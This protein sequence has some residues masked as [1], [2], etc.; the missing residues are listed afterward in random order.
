M[1]VTHYIPSLVLA[2]LLVFSG[3]IFTPMAAAQSAEND[4]ELPNF[5]ITS[6]KQ[7]YAL[8]GESFSYYLVATNDT[9]YGLPQLSSSIPAGLYFNGEQITGTPTVAGDYA[10]NFTVSNECGDTTETVNLT[11]VAADSG[12]A[13]SSANQTANVG[14]NEIPDTG[15]DADSALTISFYVLALLL[16][17]GWF[18]RRMFMPALI[19]SGGGTG[20]GGGDESLSFSEVMRGNFIPRGQSI[21]SETVRRTQS[22]KRE[23][24]KSQP[25][26]S[27]AQNQRFG[28]GIRR[29]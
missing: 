21:I 6:D 25:A 12:V 18:T 22:E 27:R 15:L 19:S 5:E 9:P 7:V 4:C 16:A 13:Q 3:L 1:Q 10:L 23:V 14:L 11:V 2:V 28:D 26:Q 24:K 17:A 8:T 29:P 20:T